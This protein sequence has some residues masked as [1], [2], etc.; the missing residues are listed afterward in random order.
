MEQPEVLGQNPRPVNHDGMTID[1]RI[2]ERLTCMSLVG[3][4][5][6]CRFCM[7]LPLGLTLS[8]FLFLL[9]IP[10]LAHMVIGS[11]REKDEASG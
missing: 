3:A 2:A 4:N 6:H 9:F 8:P 5:T 7:R 10:K 11:H 1:D